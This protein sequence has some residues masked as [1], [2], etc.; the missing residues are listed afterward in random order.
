MGG[1]VHSYIVRDDGLLCE[2]KALQLGRLKNLL[3]SCDSV[4]WFCASMGKAGR[5]GH[6]RPE[7][8]ESSEYCGQ[9]NGV[10]Q[11]FL[12]HN[13]DTDYYEAAGDINAMDIFAGQEFVLCSCR[14]FGWGNC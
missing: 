5:D 12:F 8:L 14:H 10:G 6:T 4:S 13:Q 2:L 7:E 9:C 1:D 11:P 3:L